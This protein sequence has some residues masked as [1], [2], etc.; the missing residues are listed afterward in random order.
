MFKNLLKKIAEHKIITGIVVIALILV[1]FFTVRALSGTS[2]Q[3][4]Y[5]TATV[6]RGTIITS[7]SGTGQ[8]S[9]SNQVDIKSKASG[10]IIYLGMVQGQ[11]VQKGVLLLQ[12]DTSDVAKSVRDAQINLENAQLSLAKLKGPDGL[13]VPKNKQDALDNL[14]TSYEDGFNTVAN[15]YLD[16]P[17]IVSGL[18]D[19]LFSYSFSPSQQNLDYYADSAYLGNSAAYQYKDNARQTYQTARVAYDKSFSDY[20][21]TDRSAPTSTIES[22]INESYDTTKAIADAVKSANNLIQFYKDQLSNR[23]VK[24]PALVDTQLSSLN[25]YTGK[26]NTDLLNLLSIKNTIKNDKDAITNA[27]LDLQSQEL[28]IQ[29]RKNSLAD[30]KANLA[31][32]YVYAPF[33]GTI[34]QVNVKKGDSISSG[35]AIG[36]LITK[37]QMAEISLN[38]VDIVKVQLGQKATLTF[39][40]VDGLSI[41]GQVTEID[42]I[43][44]V[45]QGVVTYNVK[46]TFDTQDPRVKPGMSTSVAIITEA[47]PNVLLVPNGAIKSSG[48]IKYVEVV[49]SVGTSTVAGTF[50]NAGVVLPNGSKQQEIT[51][52]LAND[53]STEILTGLK[54]GDII[55]VRTINASASAANTAQNSSTNRNSNFRPGQ[56]IGRIIGD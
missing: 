19:I 15:L 12:L 7:V 53:T 4:R 50:N 26:T 33:A 2:S 49:E 10:D 22:L 56:G 52:G 47:K 38:E 24:P 20:K 25:T 51:V 39:D 14:D 9:A 31:N 35:T 43:G 23:N 37:Q 18:N 11:S 6:Q 13:A 21:S 32:Y 17:S 5:V 8:V 3:T 27:D 54:E 46:V 40:A 42:T 44:T 16:L 45:S 30:A 48:N 41:S 36:T 29:Q 1:I 28:S 34:A 55:V